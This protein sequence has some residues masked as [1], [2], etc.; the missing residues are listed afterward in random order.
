MKANSRPSTSLTPT[1]N[2]SKR[3][4]F[5]ENLVSY[6]PQSNSIHLNNNGFLKKKN[7]NLIL[8]KY[9][10]YLNLIYHYYRL[11]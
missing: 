5:A 6:A 10:I 11:L 8:K 2:N 1:P 9:F 4:K 7:L 3:V